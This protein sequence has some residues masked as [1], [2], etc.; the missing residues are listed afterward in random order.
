[1]KND[2]QQPNITVTKDPNSQ[3]T[4]AGEIAA[5][6]LEVHRAAAMKTLNEK[7]KVDGFRPGKVPAEILKKHVGEMAVLDEMAHLALSKWY[8]KIIMEHK[9]EAIGRPQIN[10]TKLAAGN[11][12]EFSIVYSRDADG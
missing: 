2:A 5:G 9:I 4:I 11:P 12:L 1:M 7:A 10:I 6:L 8:P 3:V